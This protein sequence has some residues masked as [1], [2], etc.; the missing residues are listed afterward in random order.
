MLKT[1]GRIATTARN[2]T[3]STTG[4]GNAA[5]LEAGARHDAGVAALRGDRPVE[6]SPGRLVTGLAPQ[7]EVEQGTSMKMNG[8]LGRK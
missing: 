2:A 1:W 4:I 8:M 6:R 7:R 3:E 5:D